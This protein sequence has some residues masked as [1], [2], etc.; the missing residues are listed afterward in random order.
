MP[1]AGTILVAGGTG[2][3]LEH[4]TVSATTDGYAS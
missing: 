2:A 3:V 1:A 4:T